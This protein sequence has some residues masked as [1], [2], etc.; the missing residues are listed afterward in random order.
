MILISNK[1]FE[2]LRIEGFEEI[3]YYKRTKLSNNQTAWIFFAKSE[4]HKIDEYHV[5][6][7]IAKKKRDIYNWLFGE[8]NNISLKQT[9]MCGI[10]GMIWAKNQ[11]LLFEEWISHPCIIIVMGEDKRRQQIFKKA[12]VK[13]GYRYDGYKNAM[14]K[15]INIEE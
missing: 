15:K 5:M 6:F 11:M 14:F 13:H 8:S 1:E 12:L 7:A 10:E 3:V 4:S 2:R 9:G